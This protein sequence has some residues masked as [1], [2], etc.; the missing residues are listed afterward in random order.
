MNKIIVTQ[1][2]TAPSAFA[3]WRAAETAAWEAYV[4][5]L[6]VAKAGQAA[7]AVAA[8][9]AAWAAYEAALAVAAADYA[10]TARQ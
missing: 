7:L 5:A 9:T 8:E 10:G 4:A 1:V 6:A 3:A 2:T